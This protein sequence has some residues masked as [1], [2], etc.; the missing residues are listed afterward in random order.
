MGASR[1]LLGSV[2][3]L[4]APLLIFA[5]VSTPQEALTG[6]DNLSNGHTRQIEFDAARAI[7]EEREDTD[8]GLGPVYN[9]QSCTECHQSPVTGAA[10]Q[11]TELRAGYLDRDGNFHDPP[12]GSLINDR[13]I[14]AS[15]QER[16]PEGAQVRALR[17]SLS[18]LGD[19]YVEAILDSTLEAIAASQAA[20]SGGR[21]AGQL[22]Y[23]DVMEAPGTKRVGRFGW[24]NQHASLLAFSADAYL[25][26]MGI[27]SPL[28]PHENTS[29]GRPVASFD[30][31]ADPEERPHPRAPNGPDVEA[32]AR[33]MR[34]TKAPPRNQLLGST[35]DAIAGE[36]VFHRIGCTLCHVASIQTA[37]VGTVL[38]GGTLIVDDALGDR[39]IHPYSDF[40]LHDVGTGDGVVQNGGPE[41]ARKLRT[42]PLWGLRTRPRLMHDLG[43]ITRTDA[44]QRHKGEAL[45][46]QEQF[47][48]LLP[49]ERAQLLIFLDS[50]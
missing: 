42:P 46:S 29:M 16:V 38:N 28:Q 21:V 49:S 15:L 48:T 10:S 8:Q 13:A 25:N 12:G 44:I 2:L 7:F 17:S 34:S 1:G 18:T 9:A 45:D 47:R 41:S 37:P 11:I 24:K 23:A 14:H 36:E 3:V 4:I 6:F 39:I 5:V 26:E 19:G 40:L 20:Q 31:V 22:V 43:S 33:F 35:A 27:T 30:Q 32:F 50:L